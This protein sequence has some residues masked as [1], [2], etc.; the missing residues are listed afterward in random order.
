MNANTPEGNRVK[1]VTTLLLLLLFV[2]VVV[3][4]MMQNAD[5]AGKSILGEWDR[6]LLQ[7]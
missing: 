4:Q 3:I 6:C 2:T 1:V 5:T 7:L